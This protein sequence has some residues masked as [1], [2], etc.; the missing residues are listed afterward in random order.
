MSKRYRAAAIGSTGKGGFGHGLDTAFQGVDRVDFVAVADDNPAGLQAVAK[1]TGVGRLYADYRELLAKEKPD[2]VA[3]GPSWLDRRVEMV[4]AAAG[5]G[6]HVLCEK[7]LAW[8][9]ADADAM[10]AACARA[11]VQ[12][13]IAH[14][15]R[16]LPPVQKALQN[17]RAGKYGKL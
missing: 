1:K 14:Q 13:A 4:T 8:C 12:L 17:L 16:A 3:V 9:L 10:L 11:G 7:P 6:C 5:A 2:V 15:F